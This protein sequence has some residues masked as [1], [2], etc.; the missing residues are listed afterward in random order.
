MALSVQLPGCI[1][2]RSTLYSDDITCL[3]FWAIDCRVMSQSTSILI[4]QQELTIISHL[5]WAVDDVVVPSWHSRH[6]TPLTT[7]TGH[8]NIRASTQLGHQHQQ[9]RHH[10]L[11]LTHSL[12]QTTTSNKQVYLPLDTCKLHILI[13]SRQRTLLSQTNQPIM[14]RQSIRP[15][16]RA[17][18]LQA[19]RSFSAA[20]V[21]RMGAG[22]T[23][24]PKPG[25]MASGYVI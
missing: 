6:M 25:G 9:A 20:P 10:T 24:A 1:E 14:L 3:I 12:S 16:L 15:A 4:Q 17:S 23:G 7:C 13:Y 8:R 11:T 2:R 21:V 18:R 22:D 19:Y 5:R